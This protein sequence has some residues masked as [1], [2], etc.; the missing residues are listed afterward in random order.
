M[1]KKSRQK[2][3][4][5]GVITTISNTAIAVNIEVFQAQKAT[6]DVFA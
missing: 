2:G 4:I 1:K 6:F 3:H 5:L